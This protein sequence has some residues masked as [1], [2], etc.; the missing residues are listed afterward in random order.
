M[1][2]TE[3]AQAE[4]LGDQTFCIQIKN[5]IPRSCDYI[6]HLRTKISCPHAES[7]K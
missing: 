2:V 1:A 5:E 6:I 3:D 7:A 4:H